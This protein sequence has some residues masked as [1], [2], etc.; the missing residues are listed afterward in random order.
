MDELFNGTESPTTIVRRVFFAL[1]RQGYR[2]FVI[3]VTQL[4]RYSKDHD[5]DLL[6]PD[7]GEASDT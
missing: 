6:R 5:F 2:P 7:P 4:E 3:S 1:Q